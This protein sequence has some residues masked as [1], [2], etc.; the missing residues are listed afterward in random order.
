MQSGDMLHIYLKLE[1]YSSG[2]RHA[3]GCW[4]HDAA[5]SFILSKGRV[6][7]PH[8]GAFFIQLETFHPT[9]VAIYWRHSLSHQSRLM[10]GRTL[11]LCRQVP[12]RHTDTMETFSI[13]FEDILTHIVGLLPYD[14]DILTCVGAFFLM[15][16]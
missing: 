16:I 2:S 5:L 4:S 13:M 11:L 8:V 15:L 14:R 1:H 7:P 10:E 6:I 3:F 9:F 12:V